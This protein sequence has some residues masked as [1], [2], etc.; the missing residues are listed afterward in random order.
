MRLSGITEYNECA[1][2]IRKAA[3]GLDQLQE[4]TGS[5][6]APTAGFLC[7][8][9]MQKLLKREVGTSLRDWGKRKRKADTLGSNWGGRECWE[10]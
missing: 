2:E 10:N 7:E 9:E 8:E 4:D 3:K 5:R 1:K 6:C